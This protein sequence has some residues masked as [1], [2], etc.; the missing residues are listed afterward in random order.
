MQMDEKSKHSRESI[1]QAAISEFSQ[2]GYEGASIRR[3]CKGSGISNGRLFHHFKDKNE[4]YLACGQYIFQM[5]AAY[6]E[7]FEPD[8]TQD[9]EENLMRLYTHWQNFWRIHPETDELTIQMR[10]NPPVPLRRRIQAVRRQ[11]FATPLKMILHDIF[12]FFY[13][14]DTQ[15]QSFLTGVWMTLLDYTFVGIGLPKADLYTNMEQW[16][17]SQYR[18]FRKMLRVFL[19]GIDSDAYAELESDL[20]IMYH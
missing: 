17:E 11:Y 15:Q 6:M 3:I 13:P 8:I 10:I 9:V 2:Y 19:R 5:L 1:V 16:L 20:E 18:I 14:N 4:L 7:K 12:S